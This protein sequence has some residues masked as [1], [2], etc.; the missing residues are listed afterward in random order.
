MFWVPTTRFPSDLFANV[1]I[2][3]KA[4][5]V[6]W[7]LMISLSTLFS[8]MFH[9]RGHLWQS[10]MRLSSLE[11]V[12]CDGIL[13]LENQ[14]TI[15]SR[16]M[17]YSYACHDTV[18]PF[19][20]THHLTSWFL[21][22]FSRH[23]AT[24]PWISPAFR[25]LPV[26]PVASTSPQQATARVKGTVERDCWKGLPGYCQVISEDRTSHKR[27]GN[28][29]SWSSCQ[30]NIRTLNSE[31]FRVTVAIKRQGSNGLRVL[32]MLRV[33]AS[34]S[35]EESSSEWPGQMASSWEFFVPSVRR[36][37]IWRN[38]ESSLHKAGS[39]PS[40]QPDSCFLWSCF[41][42]QSSWLCLAHPT[43]REIQVKIIEN[44]TAC[45]TVPPCQRQKT[46]ATINLKFDSISI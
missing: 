20:S 7:L 29:S 31:I 28:A 38:Y 30:E 19:L 13:R 12:I 3:P 10:A 23:L 34:E 22:L 41:S 44:H 24:P 36:A 35:A 8:Y 26:A 17:T 6:L 37:K 18:P 5:L 14:L 45:S 9:A 27:T 43:P 42:F 21:W 4:G 39:K 40:T 46:I 1:N 11:A 33:L 16:G 32:K 15:S 2:C 25:C